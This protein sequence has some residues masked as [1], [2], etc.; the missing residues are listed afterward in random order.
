MRKFLRFLWGLACVS[1]IAFGLW[2]IYAGY[3]LQG[4]MGIG[5]GVCLFPPLHERIRPWRHGWLVTALFVLL[6]ASVL[7]PIPQGI[8][9]R[10]LLPSKPSPTAVPPSLVRE[11]TNAPAITNAPSEVVLPTKVP[12]D[13]PTS[14][15]TKEATPTSSPTPSPTPLPACLEVICLDVGQGDAT[16]I[17]H[18]DASGKE[19]TMMVDGGDRDTSSFVVARLARL[20]VSRLDIIVAT[21]YDADHT[22]GL[23]GC[24]TKY[25]DRGTSVYCPSYAADTATYSKFKQRLDEGIVSVHHPTPGDTIP[26]GDCH[27]LVLGPVDESDPV[28]NNR[29]IVLYLTFEGVTFYLPGDSEQAEEAAILSGGL[30]PSG[31]VDVYHVSHHGSYTASTKELLSRIRPKYC[32]I[33]VGADNPYEHPHNVVLRRISESGCENVLRTDLNGEI[34]FSVVNGEL[35]VKTEK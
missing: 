21:H 1:V 8:V 10:D 34:V 11:V 16:L 20:G 31:S 17:R 32:V 4:I 13:A 14:V 23:I 5:C 27:I 2:R 28:E 24:Y 9:Y 12:T 33:S 22:F 26:F 18:T 19:W 6:S 25:A 15:P 7:S 3:P 29:S 35:S 30:L